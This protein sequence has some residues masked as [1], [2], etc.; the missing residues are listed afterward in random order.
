[1]GSSAC[2]VFYTLTYRVVPSDDFTRLAAQFKASTGPT[3]PAKGSA[4]AAAI[5]CP[6]ESDNLLASPNLPQTP[7]E[8]ACQCVNT[9]ALKC[10]V[11]D[12][13]ANDPI[14]LGQLIDYTCSLLGSTNSTITCTNIGG[15]G[16]TGE[17][18]PLSMCDPAIKLSYIMTAFYEQKPIP[19]SCDFG[20]NA[21]LHEMG[22]L[23]AVDASNAAT[24]C[25][26]GKPPVSVPT[27]SSASVPPN[28]DQ[29]SNTPNTSSSAKP[30]GGAALVGKGAGS[31]VVGA[32]AIALGALY[33]VI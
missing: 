31:A 4:P 10:R 14:K 19:S 21:T 29:G 16:T 12:E 15:N 28:T 13:T 30:S 32:V 17:Y 33:I 2:C 22:G 5:T 3:T 26:A 8:T 20:G 9:A 7:N 1:M 18:G 24:S 11:I 23:T 25:L 6:A 27:G